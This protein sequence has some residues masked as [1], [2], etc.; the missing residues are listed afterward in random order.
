MKL[1][2]FIQFRRVNAL[3]FLAMV[4]INRPKRQL[5]RSVDFLIDRCLSIMP[6]SARQLSLGSLQDALS[7]QA[8]QIIDPVDVPSSFF[9]L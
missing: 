3:G 6:F 7:N 1:N 2:L 8:L 9:W 4:T 5:F